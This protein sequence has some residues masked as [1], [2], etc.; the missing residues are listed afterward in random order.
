VSRAQTAGRELAAYLERVEPKLGELNHF[1][2]LEV[3]L[4]AADAAIQKAFH[5]LAARL[6]PDRHRVK[7]SAADLERVVIVYGRVA[8]AYR[9]LREPAT[10]LA[11]RQTLAVGEAPGGAAASLETPKMGPRAQRFFS[12]AQAA[13]RTGDTKSALLNLKLAL[14]AEPANGFL[15]VALEAAQHGGDDP[16]GGGGGY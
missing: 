4:D 12:R 6:H 10:R 13:L 9:V 2:L 15:R 16:G 1:E 8:E 11:Y 14:A 7:L 3:P 5:A